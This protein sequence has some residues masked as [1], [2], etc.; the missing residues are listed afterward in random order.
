MIMRQTT[1]SALIEPDHKTRDFYLDVMRTLDRAR[2]PYLVGGGYAMSLYTGIPRN[3]K[4]LDLFLRPADSKRALG[5]LAHAG[6]RTEY[7]YPFWI[8]KALSGEMFVDI[9]Y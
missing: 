4:D 7:F 5:A 3:T 8:A 9:L 2:V 1:S 6:F